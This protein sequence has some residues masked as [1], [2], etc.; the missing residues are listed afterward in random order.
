MEKV[1]E[2]DVNPAAEESMGVYRPAPVLRDVHEE[3]ELTRLIEQQAARVPSHY[4]LVGALGAMAASIAF[5]VSGNERMSRFVGMWA[6]TL[7]ITGVYNKLVKT[8]GTR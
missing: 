4:F 6:P 8:L 5:E 3:S 2:K 1:G 7:L